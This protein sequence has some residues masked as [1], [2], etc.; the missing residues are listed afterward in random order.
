MD[1]LIFEFWRYSEGKTET[2]NFP[3]FFSE[4]RK[5][6]YRKLARHGVLGFRDYLREMAQ[7]YNFHTLRNFTH[8]THDGHV[9]NISCIARGIFRQRYDYYRKIYMTNANYQQLLKTY[10][11]CQNIEELAKRDRVLLADECIH[12]IHNSGS[13][14]D[15]DSL[16]EKYEA[17]K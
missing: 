8:A 9:F 2:F 5:L 13:L 11:Q 3:L 15:I 7:I 6:L 4:F 12:A 14:L 17:I 16:R 1:K 10:G